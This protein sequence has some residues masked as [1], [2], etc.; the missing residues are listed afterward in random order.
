[1]VS[2]SSPRSSGPPAIRFLIVSSTI[3]ICAPSLR[4][5]HEPETRLETDITD[6]TLK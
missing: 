3:H 2:E 1:M 5:E 6:N 4:A